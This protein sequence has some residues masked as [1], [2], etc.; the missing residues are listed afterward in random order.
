MTHILRRAAR[1]SDVKVGNN[2]RQCSVNLEQYDWNVDVL[3]CGVSGKGSLG[4]WEGQEGKVRR[5]GS[6]T[7]LVA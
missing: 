4:Y 2:L 6:E 5:P 1:F 3:R 7:S